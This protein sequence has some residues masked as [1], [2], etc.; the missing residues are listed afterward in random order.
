VR[1]FSKT[2]WILYNKYLDVLE[3][4]D[5]SILEICHQLDFRRWLPFRSSCS[6]LLERRK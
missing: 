3:I 2:P 4:V 1:A 5:E 6:W